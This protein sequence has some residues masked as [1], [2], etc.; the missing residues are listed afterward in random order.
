MPV[1]RL[2]FLL[3][4]TSLLTAVACDDNDVIVPTQNPDTTDETGAGDGEGTPV[5][6]VARGQYLVDHV[7][8]CP[9]CHTP[10]NEMGAP[11]PEQYLA[12][13]D[14]FVRLENGDCLGS[15]NLTNHETGLANRTDA[16][17]KRM[18]QDGVRPAAT[19]DEALFPVMP[20]YVF[21]NMTGEDLDA[22][23]AYLRTVPAVDHAIL[24]RAAVF[25]LP[26]PA[27]PL[28]ISAIPQP[29]ADYSD[30]EAA[31]R[32]RYLAAQAGVCLECH[33]EHLMGDPKVVDYANFFAG[34]EEFAVGLPVT[35]VS[36]N[37]TSDPETGLGKW[38]VEDI[39]KVIKQGI[40]KHGDGICPPMPSGPVGA[41]GDMT[42]E[43]ALDV[44]HYI[45]SLPPIV[46]MVED[47]CTFPPM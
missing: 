23:V 20:Y 8:A 17:I 37:L 3:L 40:D 2:S 24:R 38:T 5:D 33:T 46:N 13:A 11:I 43:D 19:G 22:V 10:R 21:H 6:P 29:L 41:F 30:Q 15:R 7:A 28:D 36:K 44:A 42:D 47:Q 31:A 16:E 12:G 27:A 14:C 39:V 4:S 18:I 26:A 32:G 45:K 35:P 34:G 9:D 25:D 1:S